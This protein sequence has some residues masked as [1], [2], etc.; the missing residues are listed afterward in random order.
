MSFYCVPKTR[1]EKKKPHTIVLE[2]DTE[3]VES[4]I[5]EIDSGCVYTIYSL[6][7]TSG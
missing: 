7:I 5:L 4:L 6:E 2:T 3:T 1:T